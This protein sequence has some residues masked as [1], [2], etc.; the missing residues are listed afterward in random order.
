VNP[1]IVR[2]YESE[3]E[4]IV[5]ETSLHASIETG[6]SLFGLWTADGNPTVVLATRPGPGAIRQRTQFEQDLELHKQMERLLLTLHG[7]QGLG[8]WHSHHQLGL[9]ELSAGDLN[10]TMKYAQRNRRLR[11]CDLLCYF[12]KAVRDPAA[13]AVVIKPYVYA[14][15]P[16]GVHVPTELIVL[17]GMSPVR[18]ALLAAPETAGFDSVRIALAGLPPNFIPKWRLARSSEHLSGAQEDEVVRGGRFVQ[19]LGFGKRDKPALGGAEPTGDAEIAEDRSAPSSGRPNTVS[20]V[21]AHPATAA[22]P[23]MA[24][25]DLESYLHQY[26]EPALVNA[27]KNIRCEITPT[28]DGSGLQLRLLSIAR[29]MVE[30][31]LGWDGHIPVAISLLVTVRGKPPHQE[32]LERPTDFGRTLH[33]GFEILTRP[34]RW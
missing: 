6:G 9:H 13:D 15:A 31:R 25:P 3:L 5:H 28:E 12:G 34:G 16:Q 21:T 30:L 32:Y 7:A 29:E 4:S 22:V 17:A 11:F 10:R 24:I 18:A 2:I 33:V 1:A 8:L 23:P 19:R 27:P 14:D 20:T 26:V